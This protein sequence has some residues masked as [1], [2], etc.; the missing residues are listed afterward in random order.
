MAKAKESELED[1]GVISPRDFTDKIERTGEVAKYQLELPNDLNERLTA[2]LGDLLVPVDLA[3]A[4]TAAIAM[5]HIVIQGPPGTGKT[6]VA[7]ALAAAFGA[8]LMTVTAH[9]DWT[10]FDVVGRQELTVDGDGNEHVVPVN[11]YFTEAALRCAAAIV[12]HFDD[13]TT[14]QAVWLLIDEMNRAHLDKAFGELFTALGSIEQVPVLLPHQPTGNRRLTLPHRF[15]IVGTLNSI[16]RQFVN[17]LGQGLKRRFT[18]LTLD[19]PPKRKSG[20]TWGDAAAT[21]LAAREYFA[22]KAAAIKA[23]V[24]RLET[25]DEKENATIGARV[26]EIADQL[27]A[28][29]SALFDLVERVRYAAADDPNPY[30]PIGTA[31]LIGTVGLAI[32]RAYADDTKPADLS[33]TLD[34]AAAV[35]LA[36]LFEAD[37]NTDKLRGLATSVGAPFDRQFSRAL[38]EVLAAGTYAV[39]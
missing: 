20:E 23:V 22:V 6:S 27:G 16:D 4:A 26:T 15:R 14:P 7:R 13:P 29:L 21:S 30:L 3:L 25:G 10:T 38:S 17:T 31:Q 24:Q 36:P 9:E 18:F 12:Q 2:A 39:G 35:Q 19:I 37:I 11:G 1:R 34:W 8:E 28:A 5:G 32:A 33:A